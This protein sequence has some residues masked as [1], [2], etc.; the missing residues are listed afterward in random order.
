M[1]IS[2]IGTGLVQFGVTANW[3]GFATGAV[4]IA[5]VTMDSFLRRRRLAAPG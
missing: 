2:S 3:T 4:I 1:I 5:A